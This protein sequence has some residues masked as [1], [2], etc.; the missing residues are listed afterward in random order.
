MTYD[1]SD[2]KAIAKAQKESKT[3]AERLDEALRWIMS[4]REG[5]LW[6]YSQL[7]RAPVLGPSF[8]R[9]PYQTAFNC[10]EQNVTRQ[11]V[12]ELHKCSTELY[13]LMIKENEND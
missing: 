10:G 9:D 11:L 4:S 13:L 12:A 8:D 2:P 7:E 6:V 1:S 3:R 5:R